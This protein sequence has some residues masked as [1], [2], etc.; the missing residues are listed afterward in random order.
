MK[1]NRKSMENKKNIRKQ[2]GHEEVKKIK[3]AK[4]II[5]LTGEQII[6]FRNK[7]DL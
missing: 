3:K 4:K 1:R 5:Y 6:I 7:V 2:K